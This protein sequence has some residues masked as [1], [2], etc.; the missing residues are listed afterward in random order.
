MPEFNEGYLN[1]QIISNGRQLK[2]E[3]LI[4]ADLKIN[5]QHSL[6]YVWFEAGPVVQ[7]IE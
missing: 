3:S 4:F 2:K 1:Q 7:W 5:V 6:F